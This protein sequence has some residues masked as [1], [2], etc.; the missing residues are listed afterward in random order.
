M[1]SVVN[2]TAHLGGRYSRID[3]FRPATIWSNFKEEDNFS[4]NAQLSDCQ[5]LPRFGRNLDWKMVIQCGK[6]LQQF[7][8]AEPY[9][10]NPSPTSCSFPSREVAFAHGFFPTRYKLIRKSETLRKRAR[11]ATAC[12]SRIAKIFPGLARISIRKQPSGMEKTLQR[13][14]FAGP[15]LLNPN[16][17]S[18]KSKTLRK[19]VSQAFQR[20]QDRRKPTSGVT[21]LRAQSPPSSDEL[22][23]KFE[24]LRKTATPAMTCNS[25]FADFSRFPTVPRM[26]YFGYQKAPKSSLEKASKKLYRHTNRGGFAGGATWHIRLPRVTQHEAASCK[27]RPGFRDMSDGRSEKRRATEKKSKNREEKTILEERETELVLARKMR[28][29]GLNRDRPERGPVALKDSQNIVG[30]AF[31]EILSDQ[32]QV[33]LQVQT[34]KEEGNLSYNVQLSDRQE[35]PR[36]GRNLDRKMALRHGKTLWQPLFTGP[37]LSNPSSTSRKFKTIRKKIL[38]HSR[39]VD[40]QV[41]NFKKEDTCSH[42]VQLSNCQDLP[43]FGRILDWKIALRHGKTLQQPLFAGSYLSNH[44]STSCKFE[45]LRNKHGKTLWQPLFAGP[46]LPNP[47]STSRKFETLRKKVSQAFQ[48]H[49]DH[50]KPTSGATSTVRGKIDESKEIMLEIRNVFPQRGHICALIL[51]YSLRVDAQLRNFKKEDAC[52]HNVQLLNRQDLPRFGRILDRKMALGMEKH[53]GGLCLQGRI[54]QTQALFLQV[55]NF[56]EEDLPRAMDAPNT[57]NINGTYGHKHHNMSVLQ[58]HVAFFDK[59]HDGIIYPSDTYRGNEKQ[60]PWAINRAQDVGRLVQHHSQTPPQKSSVAA[61]AVRGS[62]G[63]DKTRAEEAK[64][65]AMA[66]EADTTQGQRPP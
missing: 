62:D 3:S 60:W 58:Q 28:Q 19:K 59:D 27:W 2:K 31:L 32:R 46:Y 61:P 38:P 43:R 8:F 64:K 14:L 48:G 45:T 37:Y 4:C 5:E 22:I 39:R 29:P 63:E 40:P 57:E 55:R 21:R 35:L 12:N 41:Q 26:T 52:S 18:H 53:S 25:R 56:K 44:S 15:H 54:S 7:P 11:A 50:R 66:A 30:S 42:N 49:Q 13:P 24:T 51:P 17:T 20:H 34:F 36:F 6:T 33:G 47:S 65:A 16:S 9:L 23:R 10:S 1:L